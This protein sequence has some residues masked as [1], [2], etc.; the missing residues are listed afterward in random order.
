MQAFLQKPRVE[1]R[2][3]DLGPSIAEGDDEVLALRR[4]VRSTSASGLRDDVD[5]RDVFAFL[6]FLA[7]AEHRHP[8]AVLA[9]VVAQQVVDGANAEVLLERTGGLLAEHVIEPVG[10]RG[11]RY[12]TPISNASPRWSV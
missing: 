2:R 12:S 8:V 6:E 1:E 7:L 9:R 5:E 10:Q 3:R 11:H 4:P